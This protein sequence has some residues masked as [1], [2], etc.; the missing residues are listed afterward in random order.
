MKQLSFRVTAM[1]LIA[2]TALTLLMTL[3]GRAVPYHSVS[4]FKEDQGI[5]LIDV[6]RGL[7]T[8][9][10]ADP[11]VTHVGQ[12][13][14]DGRMLAYTAEGDDTGQTDIFVMDVDAG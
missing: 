7:A 5:G 1:T 8:W 2:L 11:T 14:P 3:A 6:Q 4:Y 13:S 9:P 10:V 12:W